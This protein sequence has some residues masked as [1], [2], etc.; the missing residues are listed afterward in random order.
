M[1]SKISY[2]VAQAIEHTRSA[3]NVCCYETLALAMSNFNTHLR[4]D[5]KF[6]DK[7]FEQLVIVVMPRE[8]ASQ[9]Y[10]FNYNEF[11]VVASVT[12]PK[13]REMRRLAQTSFVTDSHKFQ[14]S[15]VVNS[16]V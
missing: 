12:N 9:Y 16:F 8:K 13:I 11:E 2:V 14:L 3:I 15:S 1:S 4:E 6:L 7:P 5:S 10:G